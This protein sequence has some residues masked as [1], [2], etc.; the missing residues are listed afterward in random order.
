MGALGTVLLTGATGF[1]GAATLAELRARGHA[2]VALYRTAL[3]ST[4]AGDAGIYPVRAD[5]ADANCV[6]VIVNALENVETVV[7]CAAAMSGSA[8]RQARDTVE[9]TR[10]LC[11]AVAQS[12]LS[13]LVLVSSLAVYDPLAVDAKRILDEVTPLETPAL[14]RDAYVRG[15]LEQEAVCAE[16]SGVDLTVLRPGIVYGP[17]R[18][19]NAHVGAGLGPVLL[20]LGGAGEL[21]LAH[22]KH[23]ARSIADA[24]AFDGA[25]VLNVVDDDRPDRYRFLKAFAESGWPRFVVP[26]HW[27]VLDAVGRVVGPIWRNRP[28]LLR[29]AVLRWRMGPMRYSNTALHSSLGF[30]QSAPFETLMGDA[31]S[32]AQQ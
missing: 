8:E 29:S 27:R 9:G 19:W 17:G 12:G 13:R 7:H 31:L 22:V 20:R 14:A 4:W 11:D 5:L 25:V 6:P 32:E 1:V 3:P 2:V 30:T 16:L 10:H 26:V 28:G 23:V 15:K 21:P 24:A 18:A